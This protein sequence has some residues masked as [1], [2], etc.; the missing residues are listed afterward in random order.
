MKAFLAALSLLTVFP[1]KVKEIPPVGRVVVFFPL[2]GALY[3]GFVVGW[4]VL[5]T[6][7]HIPQSM[8]GCGMIALPLFVNG[9]F[10]FDGWCD[11]WDGFLPLAS[12][13]KRLE[14]MKDSRVGVFGLA[15][16]VI[17][18]LFRYSLYPLV[19]P[20]LWGIEF[21]WILSRSAM[22]WIGYKA[23]YPREKGTA[24][25]LVG[26]VP[27]WAFWGVGLEVLMVTLA[28]TWIV[29]SVKFFLSLAICFVV[30]WGMR[31]LSFCKIGGITG[32]VIGAVAEMVEILS[33]LV[34]MGGL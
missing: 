14:I 32:D 33:L 8:I 29:G 27:P 20:H 22:V 34:W 4:V 21:S 26:Q 18:L 11:T 7:L 15:M 24:S 10:H 31:K 23:S 12:Q 25:F 30:T 1:L 5:G 3:G 17:L 19:I 6:L 2:V 16:G 13:K 28:L 9:F